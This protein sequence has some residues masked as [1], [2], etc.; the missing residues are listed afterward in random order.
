MVISAR[1]AVQTEEM[2]RASNSRRDAAPAGEMEDPAHEIFAEDVGKE[3][4]KDDSEPEDERREG[5][6]RSITRT[7]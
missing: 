3:T 6:A 4:A 7:K 1:T 5:P 2:L